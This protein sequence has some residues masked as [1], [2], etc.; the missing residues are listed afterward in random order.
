[1]AADSPM[2]QQ[3]R[4]LKRQ[5]SDAILFFRMGDFYEMFFED[6]C[7]AAPILEI[8]L[9]ARDKSQPHPVPMCGV[10][11]HAVDSYIDRLLKRGLKVAICEQLE[12]SQS[13]H[14]TGETRRGAG[15]HTRCHH[16]ANSV[17]RQ[18]K[19][20]PRRVMRNARGAG[21]GMGRCV[22]GRVQA[23]RIHR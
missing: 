7:L 23:Q 22:D 18:R 19:Q 2:M 1:M 11:Y 9:T 17:D 5:Y 14:G 8:A 12:D 4:Q 3:Y 20:F 15:G 10:P 13:G 16:A 6:A 21:I